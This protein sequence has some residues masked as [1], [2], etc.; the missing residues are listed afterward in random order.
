M[1]ATD[2]LVQCLENEGVEYIF[3]I[4][5]SETLDFIDSISRSNQITYVPV[6]H[7]QGAAFMAYVYGKLLNKP[8]VCTATLGPGATNLLTGLACAFL[9]YA[10]VVAITGQTG[11]NQQH[12]QTHQYIDMVKIMEPATK[13]AI[14]V[15][16]AA[17][18][19]VIVRNGFHIALSEKPGPIFIELP[20]NIATQQAPPHTLPVTPLPVSEPSQQAY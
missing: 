2:V 13:W 9:D 17:T 10:P 6:R 5:G 15:K 20:E 16:D 19:P 8:G 1:K 12:K 7:E 14:Q 3:G 11:L 18:I 4:V